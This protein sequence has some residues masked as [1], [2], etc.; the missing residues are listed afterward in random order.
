MNSAGGFATAQYKECLAVESESKYWGIS[1]SDNKK[2]GL[3]QATAED[4]ASRPA[5]MLSV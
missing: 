2:G 5:W 4:T 1:M 3:E